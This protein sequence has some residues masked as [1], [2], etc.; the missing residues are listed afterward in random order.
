MAHRLRR[1]SP[2]TSSAAQEP[3]P[4]GAVDLAPR[5]RHPS[6][7]H[8]AQ[9]THREDTKRLAAG[10]SADRS[11]E[12]LELEPVELRPAGHAAGPM[13]VSP[14]VF[15]MSAATFAGSV[16]GRNA[17][18]AGQVAALPDRSRCG[19]PLRRD[20]DAAHPRVNGRSSRRSMT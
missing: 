9:L 3:V 18:G 14:S 19:R 7:R 17:D 16:F 10:P 4:A 8:G 13:T 2:T 1:R 5:P 11:W 15:F 6:F 12:V 20:R